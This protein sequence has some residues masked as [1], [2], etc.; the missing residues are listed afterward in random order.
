MDGWLGWF[1]F[2]VG[3]GGMQRWQRTRKNQMTNDILLRHPEG[4]PRTT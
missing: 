3:V 4:T 1:G 2:V